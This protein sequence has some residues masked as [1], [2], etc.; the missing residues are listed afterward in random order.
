MNYISMETINLTLLSLANMLL[1]A[2][3]YLSLK[4]GMERLSGLTRRKT[5]LPT[6]PKLFNLSALLHS[7]NC[8]QTDHTVVSI[9]PNVKLVHKS[10]IIKNNSPVF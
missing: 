6:A 9:S 3:I 2:D 7:L 4:S 10:G 1:H 5:S 8:T